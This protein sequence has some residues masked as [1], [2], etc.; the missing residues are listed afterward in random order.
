MIDGGGCGGAG[1]PPEEPRDSL[2]YFIRR[3][4]SACCVPARGY[5]RIWSA[6]HSFVFEFLPFPPLP[7]IKNQLAG[8]VGKKRWKLKPYYT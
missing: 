5:V 7:V 2:V 8:D 4:H 1:T 3:K 6:V